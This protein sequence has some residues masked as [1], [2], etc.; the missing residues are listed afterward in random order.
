MGTLLIVKTSDSVYDYYLGIDSNSHKEVFKEETTICF[1][2]FNEKDL[3][4]KYGYG[5]NYE[6]YLI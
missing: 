5:E 6:L 4:D 1:P 3:A 2:D